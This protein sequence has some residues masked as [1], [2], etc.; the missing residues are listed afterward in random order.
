MKENEALKKLPEWCYAID[1][2][3]GNIVILE[4]GMQG[5]HATKFAPMDRAKNEALVEENNKKLGVTKAQ[6]KAMLIGSMFGFDVPG[7]NPDFYDEDG[8]LKEG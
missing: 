1:D 8:N 6:A 3:T 2:V 7:V 4:R 5:Y